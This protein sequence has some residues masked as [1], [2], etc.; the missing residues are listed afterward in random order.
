MSEWVVVFSEI[1]PV[2]ASHDKCGDG[3]GRGA[4]FEVISWPSRAIVS[5]VE[6]T[7]GERSSRLTSPGPSCPFYVNPILVRPGDTVYS[8]TVM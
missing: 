1:Q 6:T 4:S 8:F 2:W 7:C 5:W 3:I